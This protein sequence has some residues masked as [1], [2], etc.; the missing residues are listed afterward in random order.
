MLIKKRDKRLVFFSLYLLSSMKYNK[1]CVI[2]TV[3]AILSYSPKMKIWL[4][5]EI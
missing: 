4:N 3:S 5:L 2:I 1:L